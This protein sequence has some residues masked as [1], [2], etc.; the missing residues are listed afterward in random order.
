MVA[1][2][3]INGVR[4][5]GEELSPNLQ[6]TT[7]LG[8]LIAAIRRDAHPRINV[9]QVYRDILANRARK[10]VRYDNDIAKFEFPLHRDAKIIR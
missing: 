9:D 8:D 1:G 7:P 10:T 4:V 6:A 2:I 3:G 5:N